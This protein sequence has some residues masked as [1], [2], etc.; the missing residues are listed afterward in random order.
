MIHYDAGCRSNRSP[1]LNA[2]IVEAFNAK[3]AFSF[4]K[5]ISKHKYLP[6]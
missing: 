1:I 3:N 2:E 5:T 4:A 6:L